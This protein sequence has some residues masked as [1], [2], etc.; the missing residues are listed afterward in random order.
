MNA[1][2]VTKK[3]NKIFVYFGSIGITAKDIGARVQVV[4]KS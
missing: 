3:T 1:D 4:V 2:P